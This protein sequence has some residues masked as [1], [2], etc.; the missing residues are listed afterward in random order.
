MQFRA[1][2]FNAFNHTQFNGLNATINYKSFTDSTVTNLVF[3]A[4]GSVNNINGF[5]SVSGAR[6]PRILQLVV[7]LVF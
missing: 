5:G 2:A 1:D 7:R 4:D 3:K 6:D